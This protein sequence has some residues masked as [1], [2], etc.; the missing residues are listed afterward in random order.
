MTTPNHSSFVIR[1]SSFVI[2]HWVIPHSSRQAG[3]I[4]PN[5]FFKNLIA[6]FEDAVKKKAVRFFS[7]DRL[8]SYYEGSAWALLFLTT[9]FADSQ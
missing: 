2:R 7:R 4:W 9:K 1:H 6:L 5:I 8:V 3:E